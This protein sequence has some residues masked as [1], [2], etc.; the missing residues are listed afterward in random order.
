MLRDYFSIDIAE[1]SRALRALPVVLDGL[2][3]AAE[4]LPMF[5]LRLGTE[6]Y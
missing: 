3:P 5:L 1:D 4:L 6:V 2:I